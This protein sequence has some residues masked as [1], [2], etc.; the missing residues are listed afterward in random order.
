MGVNRA[1]CKTRADDHSHPLYSIWWSMHVRCYNP[2]NKRWHRYG[3]RGIKVCERWNVFENFVADV[4][5]R[6]SK[7]HSLDR[8]PNKDGNYEPGNVRW[9]TRREQGNNTSQN[10]LLTHQ[11]KTQTLTEWARELGLS[12]GT[13]WA[14]I[15][16]SG[17]SIERALSLQTQA[18]P[19]SQNRESKEWRPGR[20]LLSEDAKKRIFELRKAGKTHRQIAD[21]V[22]VGS[23]HVGKI[24]KAGG[25]A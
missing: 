12:K 22:G 24:L 19:W 21:E 9:A 13:L 11:G 17:H 15:N 5:P 18:R 6:P 8:Y 10:V 20:K 7:Q 16:K 14:R 1:K 25:T 3:G 23:S 2:N 4:P